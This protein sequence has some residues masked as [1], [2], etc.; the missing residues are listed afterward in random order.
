MT[1]NISHNLNAWVK[2]DLSFE[3]C[4]ALTDAVRPLGQCMCDSY[5]SLAIIMGS[6][7]ENIGPAGFCHSID[8]FKYGWLYAIITIM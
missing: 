6:F 4:G 1:T 7:P 3:G 2:L 5:L 8:V